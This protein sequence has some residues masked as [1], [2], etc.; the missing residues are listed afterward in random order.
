LASA[1]QR[2]PEADRASGWH[3][4]R[5]GWSARNSRMRLSPAGTAR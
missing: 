5:T 3:P 1:R 4:R 2:P